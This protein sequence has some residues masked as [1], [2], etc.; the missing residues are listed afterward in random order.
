MLNNS[1]YVLGNQSIPNLLSKKLVGNTVYNFAK[2]G[3]TIKDC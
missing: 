3:A 1:A 2:D